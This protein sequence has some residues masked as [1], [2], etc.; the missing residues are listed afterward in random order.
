MAKLYTKRINAVTD[1]LPK[2]ETV[3]FILNY[4]KALKVLNV[5]NDK[6]ATILN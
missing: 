2:R 4:S 6:I 5:G 3:N 1:M